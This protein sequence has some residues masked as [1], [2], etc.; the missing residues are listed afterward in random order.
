MLVYVIRHGQTDWNAIRRLQGQKDIPLNDFGRSQ[1]VANG[2]AL[3]DILGQKASEFDYVASPLGRTRETM[4]LLRGAMGLDAHAYR[5]DDRL[6]EVSFGD[7]EGQTLPELKLTH[8]E[9]VRARKAA[10]WDFIPPGQDAESYEILSW[11][12]GAWLASVDRETVCVCHGGVIRSIFRLVTGMEKEE[13]ADIPIPQDK[14]LRVE[15]D[16]GTAEWIDATAVL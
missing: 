13:A 14:I 8:P 2:K 4:E 6:V 1:A 12:I 9:K 16:N 3:R 7:W 5:T 15:T 11:R 10:K